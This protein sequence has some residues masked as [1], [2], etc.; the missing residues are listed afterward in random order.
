[1]PSLN[2]KLASA[3]NTTANYVLKAT[4]STTIGNS[5]IYDDG[6]NV[7]I[8]TTSPAGIIDVQKNQNATT[9]FYFRNTNTTDTNSRAY[10]NIISGNV[11]TS[12]QAINNDHSYLNC[13]NNLYFQIGSN[14]L[15]Y[16]GGSEKM[17]LTSAGRLAIGRTSPGTALSVA[18]QSEAWQLA[19]SYDTNAGA[20]IGSPAANVLAFGDWSGTE[21]MRIT[22]GGFVGIG[23]ASPA[24]KFVVSGGNNIWAGVF[25]GTGTSGQ[26][27]GLQVLAGTSSGDTSFRVVNGA[28]TTEYFRIRGDGAQ[29]LSSFTYNNTVSDSPRTIYQGSG[30]GLGGISSV[31][32]SKKNIENVSNVDWLYQLNP[33]TFNYRKKDIEGNYTE[34]TYEDLNYGLIAEDTAP[35]ADFLINY[36]DKEDGTKEMVGI[37]YSRLITPL[38]KAI[39][40][41]NQKLQDQ[42]Q[43]INSLINR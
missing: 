21:R 15:F 33:V 27:F 16:N 9:N 41:L 19:L 34:E 43:T 5:L 6:T 18:G 30:L 42:Q 37:E 11:T 4:T 7:G 14:T 23:T 8:G 13:T 40:E 25:I 20:V 22:S 1:M 3:P 24:D 32:A 2:T 39:Q 28:Q 36:N 35:I 29:F 12:L 10:L 26:S 17:R 38:L 31:R